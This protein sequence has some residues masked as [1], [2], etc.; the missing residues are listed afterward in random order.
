M[1]NERFTQLIHFKAATPE[2]AE[3]YPPSWAWPWC[4]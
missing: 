4:L 2:H 3:D 1:Q